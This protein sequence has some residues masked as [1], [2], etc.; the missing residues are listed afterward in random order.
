MWNLRSKKE[1]ASVKAKSKGKEEITAFY[2]PEG[3]TFPTNKERCC[4]EGHTFLT[5]KERPG[6]CKRDTCIIMC[7]YLFWRRKKYAGDCF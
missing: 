2:C 6:I 5:N 7:R 3:H 4:P 1:E